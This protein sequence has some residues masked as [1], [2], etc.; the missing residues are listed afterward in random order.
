MFNRQSPPPGTRIIQTARTEDDINRAVDEGFRAL[1][2]PVQP[3]PRIR[4]KVS[5]FQHKV[6]G[7][8]QVWCDFRWTPEPDE[9]TEVLPFTWHYPHA[10]P[11]PYAAYLL[12]PD[13][14]TGDTVWLEDLI[15][16][17]VGGFWNQGDTWRLESCLAVWT[18]ETFD[19]LYDEESDRRFAIG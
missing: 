5:V 12:P 13:L 7:R 17:V 10:W 2:R 11:S 16:D 19:L 3:S 9:W 1:V 4:E 8:I 6:T 15:E 18:G 14:E